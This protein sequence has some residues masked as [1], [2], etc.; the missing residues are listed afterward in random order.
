[1]PQSEAR[2][3]WADVQHV[4]ESIERRRADG[5]A[6]ASP[7]RSGAG[8]SRD[9]AS[10]P[11]QTQDVSRTDQERLAEAT[12]RDHE[13]RSVA[14][15]D[16]QPRTAVPAPARR[17]TGVQADN[18]HPASR[19]RRPHTDPERP[20]VR[21]RGVAGDH[22]A[23]AAERRR[24]PDGLDALD[25]A[26]ETLDRADRTRGTLERPDRTSA[27]PAGARRT[28]QITGRPGSGPALTRLVEVERRRPA[29]T[30]ADR[31]GARPDRV[32]MWAVLLAF[33]LILVA[34]TSAPAASPAAAGV[35]AAAVAVAAPAPVAQPAT[36]APGLGSR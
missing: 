13:R 35:S 10:D 12:A 23:T 20:R 24:R 34:A 27:T 2:A 9:G 19:S 14:P 7:V 11:A 31:I 17:R 29:R 36:S 5:A 3:W 6:W 8:N 30:P 32:A 15:D 18:D 28:V 26:P 1:M 25:R 21:A 4:R 33:F 16:A 22:P